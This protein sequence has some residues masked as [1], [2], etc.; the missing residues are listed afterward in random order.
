MKITVENLRS[1][2]GPKTIDVDGKKV[3]S[4]GNGVGKSTF[5][6]TP[7]FVLTGKELSVKNGEREGTGTIEFAGITISRIKHD[8]GSTVRVN[9]KTC[10]EVA[11][12]EH[13]G[14]MGYNP[15]VLCALFD[16]E[17]ILDGETM[18]K[19]AAMQLMVDKVLSFTGLDDEKKD[20]VKAY[21][22][23]EGIDIVSIPIIQKA[24]KTFYG[25]R[26]ENNRIVKS[27]KTLVANDE[28]VCDD[29]ASD[30][31]LLLEQ[32]ALVEQQVEEATK[33]VLS[34]NQN[35]Q[36]VIELQAIID[37]D[38]MQIADLQKATCAYTAE[39]VDAIAK[40]IEEREEADRVYEKEISVL[41]D[42]SVAKGEQLLKLKETRQGI[43]ER[44][45]AQKNIL[46]SLNNTTCCPL[47]AGLP[48]TTNMSEAKEQ[49]AANVEQLRN[50]CRAIDEEI[51][52]LSKEID[53]MRLLTNQKGDARRANRTQQA[54]L[55]KDRIAMEQERGAFAT[56]EGKVAVLK[57]NIATNR[58]FLAGIV[59]E[60]VETEE[61]VLKNLK[62]QLATLRQQVVDA[63][64]NND[65]RKRLEENKK[66]L[67]EAE[68]VSDAYSKIIAE[69]NALPNK[70]FEK[71]IAPIE[72]GLNNILSQIKSD[73]SVKFAFAG[74]ALD[75]NVLTPMGKININE[76][77]TGER[78]IVNFAFKS[79]ICKLID[80]DTI[81]L[82]NTDAL[83]S[84]SYSMVENVVSKS[85]YNTLL[86]NCGDVKSQFEVL[87]M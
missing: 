27:L 52:I 6:K 37:R 40:E 55:L 31:A 17:T 65:M 1:V 42:S 26:T 73:W 63:S 2:K 14:K 79:L 18:L 15:D 83:D 39:M 76:L 11:M 60:N 9:G 81:V 30:V 16:N 50:E 12:R 77:S 48:C 43:I 4:G 46:D 86:I 49:I 22:N 70:I 53:E 41:Y 72:T 64:K 33:R 67:A 44:G 13:L 24:H 54:K 38:E 32:I 58:A 82:D 25:M 35:R 80:F 8:G 56:I 51:A 75:I 57:E 71:I 84:K 3:L 74:A 29:K 7:Y 85:P 28:A 78:V 20:M 34:A 66:K 47:Y 61:A 69:L 59:V 23:K 45:K 62:E 10:S 21:F 36:R 87:H 68:A 5:A 19:V